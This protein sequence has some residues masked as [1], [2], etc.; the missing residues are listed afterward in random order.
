MKIKKSYQLF[1]FPLD[2]GVKKSLDV[3]KDAGFD[4]VEIN[5]RGEGDLTL[6]TT[7]KELK[8]MYDYAD[9]IGMKIS[10]IATELVWAYPI[11]SG[12]K[13]K[14]RQADIIVEKM[15]EAAGYLKA[16]TIL[17]IPGLVHTDLKGVVSPEVSISPEKIPY[18]IVYGRSIEK[19]KEYGKMAEGSGLVI[20]VENVF[21]T[22]FLLSPLELVKYIDEI[23]LGTVK[24]YLDVGN[25]LMCGV[26]EHWI[27]MLGRNRLQALHLKDLDTS[28]ANFNG[29]KSLLAGD[30]DWEAVYKELDDIDYQGYVTYEGFKIY[31]YYPEEQAY[32][33]SRAI[34][35]IFRLRK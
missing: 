16:E 35:R 3:A 12:D 10:S 21:W 24:A 2:F 13:T 33:A 23:G 19:L 17:L 20:G 25:C 29:F 5:L 1:G 27:K 18:D 9:S 15:I 4:A 7:K 32:S 26:P 28:I 11:T 22:K 31:R 8:N 14:V 34:D 6:G 30:V